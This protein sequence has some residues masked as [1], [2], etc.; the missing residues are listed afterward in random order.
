MPIYTKKGDTGISSVINQNPIAKNDS[1][2]EAIGSLDEL[3]AHLGIIVSCFSEEDFDC[4]NLIIKTQHYIFS[5]SSYLAGSSLPNLSN[6]INEYEQFIDQSELQLPK[7]VQFMIP[8]G[9]EI[10]TQTHLARTVCRRAE[11]NLVSLYQQHQY[12]PSVLRLINRLSDLLFMMA[13]LFNHRNTIS[14][15]FWDKTKSGLPTS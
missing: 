12:D 6:L 3:N 14:D 13:R 4:R 1:V 10:A 7:L 2:F 15:I 5:I 9:C 8:G 11:R